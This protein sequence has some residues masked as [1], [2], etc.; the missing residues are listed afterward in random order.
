[1]TQERRV[2]YF[3]DP[4]CG[5]FHYGPNHPM[6]P[7]RLTL[8]HTLVVNY[9]L[10]D[11]MKVYRPNR[12]SMNDMISFHTQDYVEF[13]RDV[14]PSNMHTFPKEKLLTYNI[15][16]DCPIFEGIYHFCS[17]YTGASL[18]AAKYLNNEV[19]DIAINW[20]GGLHHAKKFE[21]SGFCYVNDIVIAILEL[22][23]YHPRVL[24]VDIDVHHGDGVQEAFYLTDRVMTVSFHRYGNLFFPGTGDMFEVGAKAG[25]Y[26]SINVPLKEGI[27][28]EMYFNIFKCVVNDVV[29][30]YRPT[31]IVLQCGADSL[32]CDRLGVF[33]LSIRGHGRC[34][35]MVK[36]LGLPLLVLGGGGYTVR[37]VARC[38]AYETAVLLDQEDKISNDLPY[39]PY[40]E[41][42]YPDYTLHPDLTTKLDNANTKQ[43]IEALRTTVH[44]HLKQLVL[45][46]SVQFTDVPPDYLDTF[47]LELV[48]ERDKPGGRFNR[49]E[50]KME[51]VK[52][53]CS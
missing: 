52:P 10:T 27:D 37:N 38:W 29:T 8:T 48:D 18:Q 31:A 24:Y 1:M 45:A 47:R 19:T 39:S 42:F 9:G 3:Y 26:Y 49:E 32:G 7:H 13:L 17:M 11:C 40:I 16:E 35:K 46:P 30:F 25:K 51:E 22:L 4:E 23:K 15:G 50:E 43:Y 44:D 12:A 34:V 20:S 21:A 14:T 2:V 53:L 5:N 41:F 28:D 33:N 36:T 6:K